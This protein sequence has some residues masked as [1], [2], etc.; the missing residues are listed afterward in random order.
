MTSPTEHAARI[1]EALH[2]GRAAQVVG[3]REPLED[4]R[5]RWALAIQ[6]VAELEAQAVRTTEPRIVEVWGHD[7]LLA[8]LE[9]TQAQLVAAQQA[10]QEIKA[11]QPET[12]ARLRD[13]GVVFDE[14]PHR[15]DPGNWQ[16][17]AFWI[18]TDLCEVETIASTALAGVDVPPP[19]DAWQYTESP[20]TPMPGVDVPPEGRC[21]CGDECDHRPG[22][23]VDAAVSVLPP[24]EVSEPQA[25]DDA[26]ESGHPG[27]PEWG[28][29]ESNQSRSVGRDWRASGG[30]LTSPVAQE[31][32][33]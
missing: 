31:P 28:T 19:D 24:E 25:T 32:N 18:Y 3:C 29:T 2:A 11:I 16:Q 1:R 6:S 8:K 22:C 30:S 17:V 15:R 5:M 21:T 33:E 23:I 20:S 14:R 13:D 10:L 26:R 9:A 4:V 27:R 7:E 12:L